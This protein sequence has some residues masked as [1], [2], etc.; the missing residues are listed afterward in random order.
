MSIIVQDSV[1]PDPHTNPKPPQT[2][3][4]AMDPHHRQLSANNGLAAMAGQ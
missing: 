3:A 4:G 1:F 2:F